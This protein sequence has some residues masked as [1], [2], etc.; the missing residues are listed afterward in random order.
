MAKEK[1][2]EKKQSIS[3]GDPKIDAVKQLIFGESMQQYDA[4]FNEMK[5]LIKRTR[6]EI[7]S[8]LNDT[9][10]QLNNIINE[11]RTDMNKKVTQLRS[12]MDEA[13]TDLDNKKVN[14]K[15]LGALLQEMGKQIAE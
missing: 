8:E 3:S 2:E 12:D 7:E 13:V 9:R 10:D 6:N 15:L 11:L 5:T 1:E 4:E 14:R